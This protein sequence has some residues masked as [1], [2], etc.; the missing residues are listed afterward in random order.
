MTRSGRR[1]ASTAV[2]KLYE[3]VDVEAAIAQRS[4][5]A[6][7]QGLAPTLAGLSRSGAYRAAEAALERPR[8]Q[9]VWVET[10]TATQRQLVKL[11]DDKTEFIQTEGGR[12][13]LD[14]RP[15]L[16]VLPRRPGRRDR[17]GRREAARIQRE[18]SRSSR[19]ASWSRRRRSRSSSAPWPTGCGSS[20]SL[21]RR[22]RS[23][24]REGGAG[25]S[26]ARSR[27]ASSSWGS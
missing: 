24:S 4:P 13:V 17:Q 2:D 23:G 10:T 5:P 25:S 11:L 20:R 7:R 22:S 26:F 15:I 19:R 18:A 3:N 21:S 9:N 14:L 6:Q 8:V 16:I 1:W 12:V 27:S